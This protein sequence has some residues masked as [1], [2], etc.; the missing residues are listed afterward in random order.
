MR[1]RWLI[2]GLVASLALNLFLVGAV[3]QGGQVRDLLLHNE[4]DG[5]FR[6]AT[7]E[8]GLAGARPSLG[9][10]VADFATSASISRS[11]RDR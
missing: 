4:G 7:A 5:R 6:D 1:P 9:C 10:C 2:I 11:R 8:A 3:T